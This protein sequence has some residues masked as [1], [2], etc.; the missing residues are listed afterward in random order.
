[1]D[2]A[3]SECAAL[4]GTSEGGLVELG[5]LGDTLAE[6]GF[7]DDSVPPYTLSCTQS[8]SSSSRQSAG[9]QFAP[10]TR[11]R[12]GYAGVLRTELEL[13]TNLTQIDF[14]TAEAVRELVERNGGQGRD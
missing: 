13:G 14:W 1:M 3:Q 9:R 4:F 11:V 12:N 6:I 5:E 7:G 8:A 2:A 10:V